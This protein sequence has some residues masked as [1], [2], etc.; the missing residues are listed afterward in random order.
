MKLGLSVDSYLGRIRAGRGWYHCLP[1]SAPR[2]GQQIVFLAA[3]NLALFLSRYTYSA[4]V[5]RRQGPLGLIH[6]KTHPS[7][8]KTS[9][10]TPQRARSGTIHRRSTTL[11][12]LLCRGR[13]LRC[14]VSSCPFSLMYVFPAFSNVAQETRLTNALGIYKK[15]GTGHHH[16]FH[17][18]RASYP[19]YTL[20]FGADVASKSFVGFPKP[21]CHEP[22]RRWWRGQSLRRLQLPRGER[23][24]QPAASGLYLLRGYS[25][26]REV[27]AEVY[28]YSFGLPIQ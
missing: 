7:H 10:E 18:F 11:Q 3:S 6:T 24:Q 21:R 2:L 1:C 28:A 23:Q 20:Q 25:Y 13:F 26:P 12:L 8:W 16:S 19:I 5:S 9:A 17:S 15:P 27:Q 14:L 4:C 22:G